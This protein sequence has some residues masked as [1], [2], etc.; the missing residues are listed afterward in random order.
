M[1]AEWA[2]A[3]IVDGTEARF[4]GICDEGPPPNALGGQLRDRDTDGDL[5]PD[6]CDPCPNLAEPGYE[7]S[8]LPDAD[9]DG[10][11][12]RCDNCPTVFNPP[13]LELLELAAPDGDGD[14][15]GD[16]CDW[17]P[18]F[19]SE[20]DPDANCNMEAEIV[21]YFPSLSDEP[22]P[23][24]TEAGAA[25]YRQAFRDGANEPVPCPRFGVGL[26]NVPLSIVAA[27]HAPPP[28]PFPFAPG[29]CEAEPGGQFGDQC[30]VD[31]VN[32]LVHQPD[33]PVVAGT[34]F[35]HPATTR[36][37]TVATRWCRCGAIGLSNTRA[38]RLGCRTGPTQCT[39]TEASFLNATGPWREIA[40]TAYSNAYFLQPPLADWLQPPL[41]QNQTYAF[42]N[43]TNARDLLWDF[44]ALG[45]GCTKPQDPG[46]LACIN[47]YSR[48]FGMLWN[49]LRTMT[50]LNHV[51]TGGPVTTDDLHERG[52]YFWSG[53]AGYQVIK[54]QNFFQTLFWT[55]QI[56]HLLDMKCWVDG[57]P[58]SPGSPL[59][60]MVINP[61]TLPAAT[62]PTG[63]PSRVMTPCVPGATGCVPLIAPQALGSAANIV[64]RA[65]LDPDRIWVSAS[66]PKAVIARRS[67]S[68]SELRA[69]VL[70][71][72]DAT[73]LDL[74]VASGSDGEL[75]GGR[76][77]PP[78]PGD[79][80]PDNVPLSAVQLDTL[81]PIAGVS[82][83]GLAAACNGPASIIDPE[84]VALSVTR[85]ELAVFG[86][87]VEGAPADR[88][89]T[90]DLDGTW[91]STL[92]PAD[93]RPGDVLATGY[94]HAVEA[95][96]VV[97][98]L[99]HATRLRRFDPAR[100]TLSTPFTWPAPWKLFDRYWLASG[101]DGDL[102]LAATRKNVSA[103]ARFVPSSSGALHFAG[104]K[105]LPFET[106]TRPVVGYG[107]VVLIRAPA[108]GSSKGQ[109]KP[110][111][112]SPENGPVREVVSISDLHPVPK[113][114]CP[115]P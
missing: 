98:R 46:E 114:W 93:Q 89:W 92:L 1:S 42:T 12:D 67:T 109:G 16:A 32:R 85:R 100:G 66:E 110:K 105:V 44:T 81:H 113:A 72:S 52:G 65:W 14:G 43:N 36:P 97:D 107:Q 55:Q 18:F 13:R 111:V 27:G 47:G 23:V 17:D 19:P 5:V 62:D 22:K 59:T 75:V 7:L 83:T 108:P 56:A 33:V 30:F 94:H 95:Y 37:G 49:N 28:S 70:R 54:G 103:I 112:T 68:Q 104:L 102:V 74:V 58:G 10:V 41:K 38:A 35:V 2:R 57:C 34:A 6:A 90:L 63:D 9:G 69:L 87:F 20:N 25:T 53:N 101:L 79:P 96:F 115:E 4:R 21:R 88:V 11:P 48:A 64:A 86:G 45:A 76:L 77:Q 31:V 91:R 39:P 99:G 40:V 106:L 71:S 15:I 84:G 80:P 61:A 26:G 24:T 29:S 8:R 50:G 51:V 3:Q 78:D 73:V 82:C 60:V